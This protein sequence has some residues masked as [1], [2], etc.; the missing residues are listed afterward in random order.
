[1]LRTMLLPIDFDEDLT[2]TLR[3]ARGLS[4]LGTRRVVLAHVVEASGMEGPVIA[5]TVDDARERMR[6]IAAP[7]QEAGLTVEIRVPTGTPFEQ[8]MALASEEHVDGVLAGTHAKSIVN[9]LIAGSV[10]E[11]I[12]R[13]AA[14]LNLLVRYDLMRNE[15]D[16]ADLIRRFGERVLVPTD[17]SLSAAHAF[18][19]ALSLPQGMVKMLYLLHAIDPGLTGDKLRRA[20]EGADFQLK[21]LQAMASQEGVPATIVLSHGDAPHVV[22]SEIEAQGITGIITG[23]R[24]RNAIQEALLGS[25]SMTMLKQANCPIMIVP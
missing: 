19:A 5:R 23:T 6:E 1:M 13:D 10:S 17:F 20:E 14:V 12:I 9:Q 24:G 18:T 16:P 25:V 22:L 11:R 7:L 21:N 2:L 4:A 3:L 15:D 8:I